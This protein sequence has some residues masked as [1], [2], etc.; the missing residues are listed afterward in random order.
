MLQF[1]III[2]IL[3]TIFVLLYGVVNLNIIEGIGSMDPYGGGISLDE[4]KQRMGVAVV[5]F[6]GKTYKTTTPAPG[7]APPDL[8]TFF[9]E[10]RGSSIHRYENYGRHHS[11]NEYNM[12]L[13]DQI[14]KVENE[15]PNFSFNADIDNIDAVKHF[16]QQRFG[17]EL[18]PK[19]NTSD[20]TQSI[21]G[22]MYSKLKDFSLQKQME[23]YTSLQQLMLIDENIQELTGDDAD[24]IITSKPTSAPKSQTQQMLERLAEQQRQKDRTTGNNTHDTIDYKNMNSKNPKVLISNSQALQYV[25]KDKDVQ[26]ACDYIPGDLKPTED[27]YDCIAEI[28]ADKNFPQDVFDGMTDMTGS[29]LLRSP[30]RLPIQ[31][32]KPILTPTYRPH[33]QPQGSWI[34]SWKDVVGKYLWFSSDRRN[35]EGYDSIGM[36]N[37]PVILNTISKFGVDI[38]SEE[39]GKGLPLFM[40]ILQQ[41]G[42]DLTDISMTG[43]SEKSLNI[44]LSNMKAMNL[45]ST[46]SFIDFLTDIANLKFIND[47][48]DDISKM[49]TLMDK[50]VKYNLTSQ[51]YQVFISDINTF[52]IINFN[53]LIAFEK[54]VPPEIAYRPDRTFFRNMNDFGVSLTNIKDY[55]D[56]MKRIGVSFNT[57][58]AMIEFA[59]MMVSFGVSYSDGSA[60]AVFDNYKTLTD[61]TTVVKA[62]MDYGVTHETGDFA[63]F[64]RMCNNYKLA[65]IYEAPSAN[66]VAKVVKELM[67]TPEWFGSYTKQTEFMTFWQSKLD[68]FELDNIMYSEAAKKIGINTP[69]KFSTFFRGLLDAGVDLPTHIKSDLLTTLNSWKNTNI[70][71][72]NAMSIL[73]PMKTNFN[74]SGQNFEGFSFM[75]LFRNSPKESFMESLANAPSSAGLAPKSIFKN[76]KRLGINDV[77]TVSTDINKNTVSMVQFNTDISNLGVDNMDDYNDLLFTFANYGVNAQN[78]YVIMYALRKFWGTTT[79]AYN[80]DMWNNYKMMMDK[81]FKLGVRYNTFDT[82]INYLV[83]YG[84][85]HTNFDKFISVLNKFSVIY[86]GDNSNFYDFLDV[87][88][89]Y[90]ITYTGA[91]NVNPFIN[92]VDH[93]IIMGYTCDTFLYAQPLDVNSPTSVVLY[94]VYQIDPTMKDFILI[95][96]THTVSTQSSSGV[97]SENVVYSYRPNIDNAG[98]YL[99]AYELETS[100]TTFFNKFISQGKSVIDIGILSEFMTDSIYKHIENGQFTLGDLSDNVLPLLTSYT[101]NNLRTDVNIYNQYNALINMCYL[102]P[103]CVVKIVNES[104]FTSNT[105]CP[106][107]NKT[108]GFSPACYTVI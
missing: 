103:Y 35:V 78:I 28:W 57:N 4:A 49:A 43:S 29:Y 41:C 96:R 3:F 76:Y 107:Y 84:I 15:Y 30:N 1:I 81:L 62:S 48:S 95:P 16:L 34:Q 61:I 68:T 99:T 90:N 85:N 55:F 97:T 67:Q 26:A 6:F 50:F 7:P 38:N 37:S 24:P 42:V 88:E 91:D 65:G 82:F 47:K 18:I 104:K 74:A 5:S 93:L 100:R 87:M 39:P 102:F 2:L 53:G 46:S 101:D 10:D 22:D 63:E 51:N 59:Q 32:A 106:P 27:Q 64:I 89:K 54:S 36:F 20:I 23:Q 45:T 77:R 40:Y 25:M 86:G 44:F 79:L 14:K 60:Q 70:N 19:F 105:R 31:P 72:G 11:Y 108:T 98:N 9:E 33:A 80:K 69:N 71:T 66:H 73:L 75:G 21:I 52:G 83:S 12:N 13:L 58:P 17:L 94:P 8:N 92:T 56:A